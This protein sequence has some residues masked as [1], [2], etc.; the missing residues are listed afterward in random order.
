[1]ENLELDQYD[2]EE[3]DDE[4]E[5]EAMDPALRRQVEAKLRRRDKELE[6]AKGIHKTAAFLQDGSIIYV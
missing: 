1:M 6:R 3:L 4:G 2:I 5:Y